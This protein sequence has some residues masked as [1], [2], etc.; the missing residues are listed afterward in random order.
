LVAVADTAT[1]QLIQAKGDTHERSF[2]QTLRDTHMSIRVIDNDVEFRDAIEA[3][4]AAL[5]EGP[6][7]IY[8][9]MLSD[10]RWGGFPDFL[11]RVD[12]PTCSAPPPPRR[13]YFT[14][15]IS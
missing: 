15:S 12:R 8:Q 14:P 13:R 10:G 4:R 3:T 2:L 5:A 6:D 11:E 7:Y 1:A 9:A